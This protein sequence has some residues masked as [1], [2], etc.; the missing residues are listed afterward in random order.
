MFLFL[1]VIKRNKNIRLPN[2]KPVFIFARIPRHQGTDI[3]QMY[4]CVGVQNILIRW[5]ELLITKKVQSF[6]QRRFSLEGTE[7]WWF[8]SVMKKILTLFADWNKDCIHVRRNQKLCSKLTFCRV[9]WFA[10]FLPG[11]HIPPYVTNHSANKSNK[12]PIRLQEPIVFTALWRCFHSLS[13][14]HWWRF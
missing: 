14:P 13:Y 9:L 7:S 1:S 11:R 5:V 10:S 6:Q 2:N 12:F 3:L 8:P 4:I